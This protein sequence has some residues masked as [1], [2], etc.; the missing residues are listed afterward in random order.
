[1][2][3]VDITGL[4]TGLAG[5]PDLEREGIKRA[6][7]IQG[8]G[9]GSN[10]ARSLALQAPQREQMMRQGAGGLFG[11]DTRTAGA[12]VK[13]QLANVD[14]KTRAG[15]DEAVKLIAQVD[16]PRALALQNAFSQQNVELEAAKKDMDIKYI[17]DPVN[18]KTLANVFQRGGRLFNNAGVEIDLKT[19][20]ADLNLIIADSPFKPPSPATSINTGKS[21]EAIA[22]E[23]QSD[24]TLKRFGDES[25]AMI[26]RGDLTKESYGKFMPI[27][28]QLE[29]LEASGA[30]GKGGAGTTFFADATNYLTSALQV[31]DPT[32]TVPSGVSAQQQY[33]AMAKLL[34]SKMTEMTKGAISD[35]ENR[36]HNKFTAS[37][38]MPKAVRIGKLNM[39]KAILMSANNK[40]NAEEQWFAKN[41]TTVGFN[42]AWERYT[43][44]FPRTAGATLR[45]VT[46]ANGK[47]TKKLVDNFEIVED[48]MRLFDRLYL[49]KKTSGSP[50]FTNGEETTSLKQVRDSLEQAKLQQLMNNA[51]VTTPSEIMKEDAER[52]VRKNIGTELL[53]KL[54]LEGWRVTK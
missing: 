43:K 20:V 10:L 42:A 4:L 51:Q 22:A 28:Q 16:A 5:T 24:M 54:D 3:K 13:E 23:L 37:V 9:L 47:T 1:M 40:V 25:A 52:F 46:D 27:Y 21:P 39:D 31:L 26:K 12:K 19:D 8:Q 53:N 6:S 17:V 30:I 32:F 34:K 35:R 36:E 15:Q 45:N 41:N 11:V 14:V 50:V 29:A 18:Q 49:G 7:A 33:E 38:N 2:A 44:D 48:N